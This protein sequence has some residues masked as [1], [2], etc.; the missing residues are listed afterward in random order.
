MT[1]AGGERRFPA[2]TDGREPILSYVEELQAIDYHLLD[3][4]LGLLKG[5]PAKRI[6]MEQHKN[7]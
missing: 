7:P 5:T 2:D 4:G 3:K 6:P 1:S